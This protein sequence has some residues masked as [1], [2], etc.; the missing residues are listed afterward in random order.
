MELQKRVPRE[1][2]RD[3]LTSF[4]PHPNTGDVAVAVDVEAVKRSVRNL[5]MTNKGERLLSPNIGTNIRRL[6]FENISPRISQMLIDYIRT[7][8]ENYEPRARLENI[9]VIPNYLQPGYDVFIEF[10][11][12][13]L[14]TPVR[15]QLFLE[16][17]R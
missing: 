5:V 11:V 16:R 1:L 9:D 3:F 8:I 17:I 15:L 10:T 12:L 14:E 13:Y 4:T 2:Y 6:L 7:T